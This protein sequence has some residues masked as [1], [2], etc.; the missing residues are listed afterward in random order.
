MDQADRAISSTPY[1][2]VGGPRGA[3]IWVWVQRERQSHP[4][5]QIIFI[6]AAVPKRF[7]GDENIAVVVT[8]AH[9]GKVIAAHEAKAAGWLPLY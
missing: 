2:N 9:E 3:T 1:L 8:A 5:L 6:E 7:T 4:D